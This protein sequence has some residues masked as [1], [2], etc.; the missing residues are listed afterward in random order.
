MTVSDG[1]LVGGRGAK[2]G[3]GPYSRFGELELLLDAR[4][5]VGIGGVVLTVVPDFSPHGTN[6][7]SADPS[8]PTAGLVGK[9]ASLRGQTAFSVNEV[10]QSG[11]GTVGKNV[12]A[13]RVPGPLTVVGVA[14]WHN[15]AAF[16]VVMDRQGTDGRRVIVYATTGGALALSG[17]GGQR[18]AIRRCRQWS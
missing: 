11:G 16:R 2:G 1:I 8:T 14:V 7:L 12:V 9:P 10:G 6:F 13:R 15:P 5:T 4:R 17:D 3:Y 18:G